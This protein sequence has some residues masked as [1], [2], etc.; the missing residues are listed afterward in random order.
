MNAFILLL[1]AMLENQNR[2]EAKVETLRDLVA[3]TVAASPTNALTPE[4]VEMYLSGMERIKY[5]Q[6]KLKYYEPIDDKVGAALLGD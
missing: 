1:S 6:L 2:I 4:Q 3:T 5:G